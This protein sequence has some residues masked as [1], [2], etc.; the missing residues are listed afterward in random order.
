MNKKGFVISTTL[1]GIFGVMLVTVSTILFVLANNRTTVGALNDKVK[2][3]IEDCGT[4]EDICDN[5][6]DDPVNKILADNEVQIKKIDTTKF[7]VSET[8]YNNATDQTNLTKDENGLFVNADTEGITYFFR[9]AVDNNYFKFA[10]DTWRIL[11]IN[12]DGSIRLIYDGN[13]LLGTYLYGVEPGS[14]LDI[15]EICKVKVDNDEYNG[16]YINPKFI[17]VQVDDSDDDDDCNDRRDVCIFKYTH[18]IDNSNIG[19]NW[20]WFVRNVLNNRINKEDD[21]YQ[22]IL[23]LWYEKNLKDTYDD[24]I[25]NTNTFCKHNTEVN[26]EGSQKY[27]S[28]SSSFNCTEPTDFESYIKQLPDYDIWDGN[29][30][31]D[32]KIGMLSK[33]ELLMAG[34]GMIYGGN[35]NVNLISN[36]TAINNDMFLNTYFSSNDK[37]YIL[38]HTVAS[39]NDSNAIMVN[40]GNFE[41]FSGIYTSWSRSKWFTLYDEEDNLIFTSSSS[42]EMNYIKRCINFEGYNLRP[43]VNIKADVKLTGDGTSGNPYE[44]IP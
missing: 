24:F 9:G 39:D 28:F 34:F 2:M 19:D 38:Y 35:G 31:I 27:L 43:V 29:S 3:C 44:I 18:K 8:Y 15:K 6:G 22:N 4:P 11:R 32:E 23:N 12:S 30:Y 21:V 42:S 7:A 37:P 41:G 10:D 14:S 16:Y 26:R 36:G 1:Y 20:N 33:N 25:L 5:G 40:N 17:S 13:I